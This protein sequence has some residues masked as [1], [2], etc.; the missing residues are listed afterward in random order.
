MQ[1]LLLLHGA[2]GAAPMLEPLKQALQ[3]NYQV[4]TL[5][6]SGHGGLELS[7][8]FTMDVFAAD[9]KRLLD[10][11]KID[12]VSIFGY[13]MGGYAALYFALQHP[14][15]VKRI[16]TLAT[17]FAWSPATAEK[18]TK[19][20][21]PEKI[22]EKVPKF[23][24]TLAQRHAPQ[25]WKDIMHRTARMMMQLGQQPPLTPENLASITIPVQV[26]VGDQDT[27]VSVEETRWAFTHLPQA[28]LQVLPAT[29]HP[30]ETIPKQRL[31]YEV[32][33]FLGPQT[34]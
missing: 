25:N 11:K 15:R 16:Y 26:S 4:H 34:V 31:A 7:A 24:A 3:A 21:N 14:T 8:S 12:Q 19:L 1:H 29:K 30:L 23:A 5:N 22:E 33:Q 2:L 17:K 13:S 9:I 10:E 6:F 28:N 27:M 20:L 18:E 32:T